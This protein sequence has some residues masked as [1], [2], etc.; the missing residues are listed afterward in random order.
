MAE[1]HSQVLKNRQAVEHAHVGISK[2]RE[3]QKPS[4]KTSFEAVARCESAEDQLQPTGLK[5]WRHATC[6]QEALAGISEELHALHQHAASTQLVLKMLCENNE[7]FSS[8]ASLLEKS[9][10]EER[11]QRDEAFDSVEQEL[12]ELKVEVNEERAERCEKLA[13]VH[14]ELA[15]CIVNLAESTDCI[16][17]ATVDL[18]RH[19]LQTFQN[20]A[21][22][23]EGDQR[24]ELLLAPIQEQL[25]ALETNDARLRE[26]LERCA[27]RLENFRADVKERLIAVSEGLSSVEALVSRH[28][29]QSKDQ[30]VAQAC[31]KAEA[32]PKAAEEPKAA[33][34][35]QGHAGEPMKAAAVVPIT[36]ERRSFGNPGSP[37]CVRQRPA[38][39]CTPAPTP[40]SMR[41]SLRCGAPQTTPLAAVL[42]GGGGSADSDA[43]PVTPWRL[44]GPS[45]ESTQ[46]APPSPRGRPVHYQDGRLNG[47]VEYQRQRSWSPQ[48]AP[49]MRISSKSML[50]RST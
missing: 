30:Q 6:L 45:P 35:V 48:V 20:K 44:A 43:R 21:Q 40:P 27:G 19:E 12:Q 49:L 41:R 33:K 34:V 32:Q 37:E 39:R 15:S 16:S 47:H 13:E 5:P 2:V 38:T 42:A 4:C 29:G 31:P 18:S 22:L 36:P 17:P 3:K 50:L 11:I 7:S 10:S 8:R 25:K 14:R 23:E 28:K 24:Q 46:G 26:D 1:I 9:I